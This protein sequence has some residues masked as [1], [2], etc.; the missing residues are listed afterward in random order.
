MNIDFK[1]SRESLKSRIKIHDLYGSA[2]L[3]LWMFEKLKIKSGEKILDLG[4]GDGK[5]CFG[6]KNYSNNFSKIVLN[7]F[8]KKNSTHF[9]NNYSKNFSNNFQ[10]IYIYM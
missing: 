4:C 7:N 9:S 5:Q 3:D 1:E 6:L 8:S 2:N 10:K